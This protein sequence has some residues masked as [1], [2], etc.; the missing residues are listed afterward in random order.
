MAPLAAK[1][2]RVEDHFDRFLTQASGASHDAGSWKPS[3]GVRPLLHV[4][5]EEGLSEP[6]AQGAPGQGKKSVECLEPT[7]SGR[8]PA[9]PGAGVWAFLSFLSQQTPPPPLGP[10]RC[11]RDRRELVQGFATFGLQ[12]FERPR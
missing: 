10:V 12:A 4:S 6:G 8:V 11:K 7:K 2:R 5:G 3:T 1:T 9:L